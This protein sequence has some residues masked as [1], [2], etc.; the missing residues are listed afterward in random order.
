MSYVSALV[1]VVSEFV[2]IV[3]VKSLGYK[4]EKLTPEELFTVTALC[5]RSLSSFTTL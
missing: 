1:G 2:V 5:S 4:L 3:A